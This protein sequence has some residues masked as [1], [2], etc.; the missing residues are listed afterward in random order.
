MLTTPQNLMP[1]RTLTLP[2]T[3][4]TGTVTATTAY[5]PGTGRYTLLFSG[6]DQV[7][8]APSAAPAIWEEDGDDGHG[9]YTTADLHPGIHRH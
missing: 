1:Q 4:F 9:L 5:D 8:G 3:C 7:R 2:A 6:N